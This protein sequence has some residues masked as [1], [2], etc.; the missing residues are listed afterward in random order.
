M[1][2]HSYQNGCRIEVNVE[3]SWIYIFKWMLP[4]QVLCLSCSRALIFHMSI[5]ICTKLVRRFIL[6]FAGWKSLSGAM[7]RLF[8]IYFFSF[9]DS[10]SLSTHQSIKSVC[11]SLCVYVLIPGLFVWESVVLHFGI[12]SQAPPIFGQFTFR[13]DTKS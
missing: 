13:H 7:C 3:I 9:V 2:S 11:F 4:Y 8:Y 12:N 1:T 6:L 5:D 10:W